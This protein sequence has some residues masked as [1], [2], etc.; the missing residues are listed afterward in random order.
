MKYL[1][2]TVLGAFFVLFCCLPLWGQYQSL[3]RPPSQEN[4]YLFK[5]L[6]YNRQPHIPS[7]IDNRISHI[8]QNPKSEWTAQDS[9]FFAYKNVYLQKYSLALSVFSRLKTDTISGAHEQSLYRTTLQHL[10][11]YKELKKYNEMTFTDD[12]TK[13]YSIKEAFMD[14]TDAYIEY[15]EKGFL[16]DSS[17]IFPILQ[18]EEVLKN[19][20]RK[21]SP[22]KNKLVTIAFAI[23]STFRQFTFLHDGRDVVLSKAFEEMGDY[24]NEYL[25]ITNAYFYYA[26]A[27]HY[28]KNNKSLIAK[29]NRTIDAMTAHNYLS[30]SFKHKFGRILKNRYDLKENI[31]DSTKNDIDSTANMPPPPIVKEKR[32]YLP[33]LDTPVLIIIIIAFMLFFVLLFVRTKKK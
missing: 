1:N 31:I 18:K 33:W 26:A 28:N 14:L 7:Y 12:T 22:Y 25:Y 23:D 6:R 13:I 27:L 15:H 21:A 16:P 8:L 24:Q 19:V 11:R 30:I 32:D 2:R 10:G 4:T 20:N 5:I 3:E 29:Y 17:W 9:L